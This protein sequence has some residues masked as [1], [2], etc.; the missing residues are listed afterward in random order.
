MG[1]TRIDAVICYQLET[2]M[3]AQVKSLSSRP[4]PKLPESSLTLR[5]AGW[6]TA[7]SRLARGS[8]YMTGRACRFGCLSTAVPVRSRS[9]KTAVETPGSVR[10]IS[11][12]SGASC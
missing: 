4:S 6:G 2:R 5:F 8:R 1:F 12:S 7:R 10:P 3:R 9:L 11:H